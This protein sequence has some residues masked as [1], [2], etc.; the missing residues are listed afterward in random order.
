MEG[1]RF[2]QSNYQI[3]KTLSSFRAIA[4][5][6]LLFL[7]SVAGQAETVAELVA[8]GDA[9]DKSFNPALALQSY[10]PAQKLAPNDVDLLLSIARQ[11]RHLMCDVANKNDK[12]NYGNISLGFAKRAAA[13]A[14]NNSDAQLS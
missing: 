1:G 9:A 11:Y 8:K 10:L 2:P 4:A 13:L 6:S 14:P 3:M 7:G 12:L 5:T